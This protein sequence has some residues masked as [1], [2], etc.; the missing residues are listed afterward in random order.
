MGWLDLPRSMRQGIGLANQNHR[1]V[2]DGTTSLN[3]LGMGGSSMTPE[4]FSDLFPD[5]KPKLN[6][7]D[8]VNPETVNDAL[9]SIDLTT[10]TFVVAS[11]SGTTVEPLSLES[12]FRNSLKEAG[13]ND[14]AKHFVAI[15]DQDTPLAT[16]AANGDFAVHLAPPTNVGGRFS[17]LSAFGMFPASICGMPTDEM[18]RSAM[19]M[20]DQC[21]QE[22]ESNPGIEL[23]LFM[24]RNALRGRDKV[25][26]A[27]SPGMERFGLWL[28]QLL[29]ES[30]GKNGRGLVPIAGEPMLPA[31]SYGRDRQFVRITL[32]GE[33][34]VVNPAFGQHPT[35]EIEIPDRPSIAGEF[36]RWEFATAVAAC[37]IGV[38]PFDQPDVE[39]AKQ[40]ARQAL[41][42]D[43]EGYA[44]SESL[45]Q[46]LCS[47]V[48]DA[49]PDDYVAIAAFL[50][51]S[52]AL[53]G[54]ASKLRAAISKATGLATTFGYGPRYL[55]ST[56]QLH[57]GGPKTVILL[58]IT[59]EPEND[60]KVP[61]Q[62]FTL[63]QLLAA[64]ANGD[65]QACRAS[66]RRALLVRV[67]GDPIDEII[68]VINTIN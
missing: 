17:A 13:S 25:T 16:R 66:G 33:T 31:A 38:Y 32:A 14:V 21:R 68:S 8:T 63:G 27:M 7:F 36:F 4:V 48:E 47:I 58:A 54:A 34:P 39:S 50:P 1:T 65:V 41:E 40:L 10:A 24:A 18:A 19:A 9:S 15:S 29:A 59:Q 37:A 12:V 51:E 57:K 23:G 55:H 42:T 30:T 35:Y 2:L 6:V 46:T 43:D 64:Q 11:K 53:T 60:V 3:I 20:A 49:G 61:G 5:T 56:G 26:F 52:E 67:S 62:S 44:Y 45:T 28:E 22:D